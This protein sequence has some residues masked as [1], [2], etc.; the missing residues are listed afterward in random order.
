MR[1]MLVGNNFAQ[2]TL[3][4]IIFYADAAS[5]MD[6]GAADMRGR[7]AGRG[8]NRRLNAVFAQIG[9]VLINGMGFARSR[10]ARQKNVG[11]GF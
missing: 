6:G 8:G 5:G 2:F 4:Q 3:V 11:A 1:D 7:D 9:Y 10:L